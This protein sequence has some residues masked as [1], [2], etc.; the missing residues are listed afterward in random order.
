M[1][2]WSTT[3]GSGTIDRAY[4]GD[5]GGGLWRID[6]DSRGPAQWQM[7]K[8]AQAGG[9]QT[10]RKFLHAVDAV[11]TKNWTAVLTGSGDREKPLKATGSDRFYM[12]KD[13]ATAL[14]VASDASAA[15][16][17]GR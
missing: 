7:Y 4:R 2:R 15:A 6:F 13:R 17:A 3:Q 14:T 8:L 16:P 11:V 10:P 12:I 9:V 1:S 5:A